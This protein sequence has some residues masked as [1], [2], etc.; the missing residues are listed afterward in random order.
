MAAQVLSGENNL[1]Y[2]NATGQNVRLVINYLKIKDT[3]S[4]TPTLSFPGVSINLVSSAAANGGQSYG[5]SL[6]YRGGSTDSG[7]A[8]HAANTNNSAQS[9]K[10]YA[11]PLEIAL[12]N[13][14]TFSIS[15]TAGDVKG[16][17]IIIIPEA[18]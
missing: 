5:K 9:R 10:V 3:V 8:E 4:G 14:G 1:S 6:A 2:T 15:G 16:Y 7:W 17:N 12:A 11:I 18:G 13:G